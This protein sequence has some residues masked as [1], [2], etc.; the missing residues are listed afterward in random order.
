MAKDLKRLTNK[1]RGMVRAL[2]F[3]GRG[4]ELFDVAEVAELCNI[5]LSTAYRLR[6]EAQDNFAK[7]SAPHNEGNN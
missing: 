3:D 2:L 6:R 5:S 4:N 1:Q 7:L